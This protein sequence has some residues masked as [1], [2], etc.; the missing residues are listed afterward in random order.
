MQSQKFS[1]LK[2]IGLVSFN[3]VSLPA[4]K[5]VIFDLS[6]NE[7]T[8][9]AKQETTESVVVMVFNQM[10]LW[11]TNCTCKLAETFWKFIKDFR[12]GKLATA[13]TMIALY[14]CINR[15]IVNFEKLG[16]SLG[17]DDIFNALLNS[18]RNLTTSIAKINLLVE[19]L[20]SSVILLNLYKR[21]HSLGMLLFLLCVL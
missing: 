14:D 1:V 6:I 9:I 17:E 2:A 10:K 11:I 18:S 15:Y 16:K 4:D 19:S 21:D 5:Q 20:Y 13:P 3:G 7:L 8:A 12:K